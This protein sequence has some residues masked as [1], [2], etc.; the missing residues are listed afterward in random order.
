V[1]FN[2]IGRIADDLGVEN[3]FAFGVVKRGNGHAPSA[4]ARD[5]PVGTG[6]HQ[7]FDAIDAP[8]RHP[9]HAVNLG[10]SG[11]AKGL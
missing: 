6:L 9:F 11:G 5:A 7:A 1:F 8:V 10:K 3:R 2:Q 4:L